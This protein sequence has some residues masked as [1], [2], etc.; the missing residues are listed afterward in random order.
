M[1]QNTEGLWVDRGDSGHAFL[2]LVVLSVAKPAERA[3][4]NDRRDGDVVLSMARP[5]E[6]RQTTA[7]TEM[8]Q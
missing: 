6:P 2:F 5:A 8:R 1:I 7:G 3:A 4:A